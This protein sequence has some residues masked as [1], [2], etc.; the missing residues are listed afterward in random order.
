[1]AIAPRERQ[2]R[3]GARVHKIGER[4]VIATSA[5]DFEPTFSGID[6]KNISQTRHRDACERL[7]PDSSMEVALAPE[8]G[9]DRRGDLSR[10][11]MDRMKTIHPSSQHDD[12]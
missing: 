4:D 11:M 6:D 9:I 7:M 10:D 12:S 3:D 8:I 5:M 1:V 2:S